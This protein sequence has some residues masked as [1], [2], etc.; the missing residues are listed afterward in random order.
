MTLLRAVPLASAFCILCASISPALATVGAPRGIAPA[1]QST[2]RSTAQ[3]AAQSTSSLAAPRS[4]D[5]TLQF[6]RDA[7]Q[8]T[9]Y[10]PAQAPRG[11]VVLFHGFSRNKGHMRDLAGRLQ[12][13]GLVVLTPTLGF[14]LIN[15][16]AFLSSMEDGL[17]T[18]TVIPGTDEP[19]P[20]Q[21]VVAGH[22]AGG[23]N[24]ATLA[25]GLRA[26]LG[27]RVLG[28][29][30][31][32]PVE[33]EGDLEAALKGATDS[34]LEILSLLAKAGSCNAQSNATGL[35]KAYPAP[36]KGI[37]IT[38]GTHCDAEGSTSD[39][40]CRLA[41]GSASEKTIE[42]TLAFATNWI[43][44]FFDGQPRPAYFP[45]GSA[46]DAALKASEASLLE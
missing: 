8:A 9:W 44:G 7:V 37:R 19:V 17:W 21:V 10:L 40:A 26:S 27:D 33:R 36:F 24:A 3:A 45:G 12:D 31:L 30:L 1:S 35:L 38:N 43:A 2:T 15:N 23:K 20:S 4:F 18:L 32:D 16:A 42:T 11:F 29:V 28:A 41:C 14:G 6:G 5:G 22:S 25:V 39:F 34:K 46:L 13:E